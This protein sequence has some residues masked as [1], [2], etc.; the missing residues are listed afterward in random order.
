M[1][2]LTLEADQSPCPWPT[3]EQRLAS[4]LPGLEIISSSEAKRS[5]QLSLP[6][7]DQPI[8]LLIGLQTLLAHEGV[9]FF[10]DLK[11]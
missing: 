1:A 3:I 2:L 9:H 10:I 4:W 5:Y 7:Q 11:S 6:D 8:P